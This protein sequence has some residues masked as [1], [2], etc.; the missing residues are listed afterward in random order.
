MTQEV[1]VDSKHRVVLP[2]GVRQEFGIEAGSKLKVSVKGRSVVLTKNVEPEEF[3]DRMEGVIRKGS[4][5]RIS[6]TLKLKEI[7]S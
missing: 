7:W 5:A 2:E 4:R 6:E 1:K 3:I